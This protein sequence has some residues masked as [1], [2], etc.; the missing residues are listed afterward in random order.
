MEE[1]L[2]MAEVPDMDEDISTLDMEDE[3]CVIA[4]LAAVVVTM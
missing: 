2:G 3:L 4:G 1:A